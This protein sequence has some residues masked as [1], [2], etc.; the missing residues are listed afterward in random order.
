M[1][2]FRNQDRHSGYLDNNVDYTYHLHYEDGTVTLEIINNY[3]D[4][5]VFTASRSYTL[6]FVPKIVFYN[7]YNAGSHKIKRIEVI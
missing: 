5:V 4:T 7:C 6:D 2:S 3:T 1:W